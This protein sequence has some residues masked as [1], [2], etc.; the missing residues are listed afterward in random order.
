MPRLFSGLELP[1]DVRER[2]ALV[3]G[4]LPGAKWVEPESLHITLRFAGDIDNR[5]ADELAGF[6]DDVAADA[7]EIRINGLGSFGG[8]TPRVIWAGVEGGES[9]A[10]LHR[11]HERAARSAGLE[12]NAQTFRPH[13]T[14]ARLRGTRPDA[15]ARFLGS[16]GGLRLPPFLVSRFVLFSSRPGSGGGPYVVEQSYPLAGGYDAGG[17]EE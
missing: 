14:L 8:H 1:E 4:P 13:V 2:L 17:G 15:V 6:L 5:V 10:A 9:L 12:P 16:R 3:R 7:F 11:A